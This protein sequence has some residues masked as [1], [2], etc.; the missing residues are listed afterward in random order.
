M[1]LGKKV[2]LSPGRIVLREDPAPPPKRDRAPRPNFRS[3]SI[4]AKQSPISAT[5]EH[6]R[7]RRSEVEAT[8]V[9]W[10]VI[11]PLVITLDANR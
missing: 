3:M 11:V 2:G 1:P 7:D 9:K 8:D 10:P 6:L 4:V 5:A